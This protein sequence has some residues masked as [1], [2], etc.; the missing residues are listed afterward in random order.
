MWWNI[1]F[2]Y[3]RNRS[4][5]IQENVQTSSY[6]QT[7]DLYYYTN[8]D[9]CGGIKSQFQTVLSSEL[10]LRY[11]V[12][13]K[14]ICDIPLS[15][16]TNYTIVGGLQPLKTNF[17]EQFSDMSPFCHYFWNG[18]RLHLVA[19]NIVFKYERGI[20]QDHLHVRICADKQFWTDDRPISTVSV[21]RTGVHIFG[22]WEE[23]L[24]HT[25]V[26]CLPP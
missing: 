18:L 14:R 10:G 9:F 1:L 3:Q 16:K 20:S 8:T 21:N 4:R 23:D 15:L 19:S 22:M 11:L 24:W 26:G 7:T 6:G 12:C 25:M 17:P 5:D 2:K 13:K